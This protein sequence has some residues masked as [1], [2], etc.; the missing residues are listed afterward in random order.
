MIYS[1]T[2][3]CTP[4]YDVVDNTLA[5]GGEVQQDI[6]DEPTCLERCA[7][8]ASCV[9]VD[10]DRNAGRQ[11]CW[12]HLDASNLQNTRAAPNVFHHILRQRCPGNN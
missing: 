11:L 4:R 2:D 1:S 3:T 9:A 6:T 8:N 5:T 12:F 7:R 10:I